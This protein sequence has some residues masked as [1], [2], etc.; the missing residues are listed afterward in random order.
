MKLDEIRQ[1]WEE[2]GRQTTQD[3]RSSPTSRDPFLGLLERENVLSRLTENRIVLEVGCGDGAHTLAYAKRAAHVTGL[4][5]ASTLI[6]RAEQRRSIKQVTNVTFCRGS[7]L[8]LESCLP[9]SKFDVVVSQRCLINLPSWQHQRRALH[10]IHAVLKSDGHLIMTEGF[11]TELERLNGLRKSV[12]LD[13]IVV[14]PYNR[15]LEREEFEP[16]VR[17]LFE[18]VEMRHYGAYLL[19]SRVLHPAFVAPDKPGHDAR[20]N[21]LS[22]RLACAMPPEALADY[23]YN[24][25]Y[26]LRKKRQ[27]ESVSVCALAEK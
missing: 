23:S 8:D 6:A 7:V 16:F 25:F 9:D 15:N 1:H 14:V 27:A 24:L 4:D 10:Q 22:M 2:Q 21:E 19:F 26:V 13:P 3:G 18:I 12:E 17:E 11:Q 5:I 20:F